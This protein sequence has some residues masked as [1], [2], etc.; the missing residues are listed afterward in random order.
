[1]NP[2][3]EIIFC[4]ELDQRNFVDRREME[5]PGDNEGQMVFVNPVVYVEIGRVMPA[6]GGNRTPFYYAIG[7]GYFGLD[8]PGGEY[9]NFRVGQIEPRMITKELKNKFQVYEAGMQLA[10]ALRDRMAQNVYQYNPEL[11]A[12]G[13]VMSFQ[14]WRESLED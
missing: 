7:Y 9:D 13:G 3:A 12:N 6:L 5:L 11:N 2:S 10:Y 1:M 14:E 8:D 4:V